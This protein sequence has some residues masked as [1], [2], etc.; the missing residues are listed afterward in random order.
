MCVYT[1]HSISTGD[2]ENSG[3]DYANINSLDEGEEEDEMEG[4]DYQEVNLI[5]TVGDNNTQSMYKQFTV[6][7]YKYT[8]RANYIDT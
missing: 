6:T 8:R 1:S 3:P 2:N 4:E 7:V 5:H